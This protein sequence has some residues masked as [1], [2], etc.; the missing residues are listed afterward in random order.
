MRYLG[1]CSSQCYLNVSAN[2]TSLLLQLQ[3][4]E[5]NQRFC[6][7]GLSWN[8]HSTSN[9]CSRNSSI[10]NWDLQESKVLV[11]V[12]MPINVVK[13]ETYTYSTYSP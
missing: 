5:V 2:S 8:G 3:V 12:I 13:A 7:C 1:Y 10:F 11:I 9:E 4:E 6:G